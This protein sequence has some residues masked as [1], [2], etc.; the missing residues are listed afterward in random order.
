MRTLFKA[1][2]VLL[3]VIVF[4]LLYWKSQSAL[5]NEAFSR[6]TKYYWDNFDEISNKHYM[7]IID[8]TKPSFAERMHIY[9]IFTGKVTSHLVAHGQG[10]STGHIYPPGFSNEPGSGLSSRGFC[11]TRDVYNGENGPALRLLG[12]ERGRNHN[13]YDR[14]IS[15]RSAPYVSYKTVFKNLVKYYKP[16]IGESGGDL[17]VQPESVDSIISWLKDGS[18]VYIYTGE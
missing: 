8:F 12:L 9:D 3:A 4:C 14:R 7:T 18:L 1:S 2:L 15:I 17:V 10:E 16:M 5:D 11:I 13:M 6:A